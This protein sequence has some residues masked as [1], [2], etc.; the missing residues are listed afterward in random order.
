MKTVPTHTAP[1]A[2]PSLCQPATLLAS[3]FGAG[4]LP[5]APG[6]WGSLAA[7]PCAVLLGVLCAP[8]ALPWC[9][10][11]TAL[12]LLG[13][14]IWAAGDYE[15]RVGLADPGPVVIDEVVGQLITLAFVPPDVFLYTIGFLL[16][17]VADIIKPWPA[18]WADSSLKGGLGV[19][20]DD[21]FAGF[22]AA[23]ALW[24]IYTYVW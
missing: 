19:M 17:R 1:A 14:G 22:Y 21:V 15:R 16:F 24:G 23:F 4:F 3:W 10:L 5:I 20:L 7:L 2:R 13:I 18:C 9:M 11:G 12:I 6:T 8:A